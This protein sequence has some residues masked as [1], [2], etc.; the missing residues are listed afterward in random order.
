[1]STATATFRK[2]RIRVSKTN[3]A[4]YK[5]VPVQMPIRW[6]R[7]DH[8][9]ILPQMRTFF[10]VSKIHDLAQNF[11]KVGILHSPTVIMLSRKRIFEYI[12]FVEKFW[13]K[14]ISSKIRDEL[15]KTRLPYYTALIAGE[16]RTLALK[17]L[18]EKGCD[19][20]Q[21]QAMEQ[22]RVLV[23]GECPKLHFHS[24]KEKEKMFRVQVVPKNVP[25]EQC[26]DIQ[27]SE[28]IHDRPTL[29]E[30]AY[31]LSLYYDFFRR[32]ASKKGRKYSLEQFAQEQKKSVDSVRNAIWYCELPSA[33]RILVEKQK[34]LTYS[35]SVELHRL[36]KDGLN[37]QELLG[38]AT[39]IKEGKWTTQIIR[40]RVQEHFNSKKRKG[41][42]EQFL[43]AMETVE[44]PPLPKIITRRVSYKTQ[45]AAKDW[46][47][48]FREFLTVLKF[49]ETSAAP[50]TP[51]SL[52]EDIKLFGKIVELSQE[53]L[54]RVGKVLTRSDEKVL[55]I[56]VAKLVKTYEIRT[57]I[58]AAV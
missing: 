22:G 35:A 45:R 27:L 18:W 3:Q 54:L 33:I 26:M 42:G 7:L 29:H 40:Q 51:I 50:E 36:H 1:M 30:E 23:S 44:A 19:E 52:G 55:R 32:L 12:N 6:A 49:Y 58:P 57:G 48:Y 34:V 28:N 15:A 11:A 53:I 4:L 10:D 8:V 2:K 37:T 24:S 31:A 20:C 14:K 47:K 17:L 9:I 39:Q 46:E 25:F 38:W 56:Q 21:K 41:N 16:R 13:G 5:P 43:F